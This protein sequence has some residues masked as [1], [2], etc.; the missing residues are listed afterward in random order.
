MVSVK[1]MAVKKMEKKGRVIK[2]TMADLTKAKK[3][4]IKRRSN[5]PLLDAAIN[6]QLERVEQQI[7]SRVNR[8]DQKL[9]PHLLQGAKEDLPEDVFNKPEGVA[10]TRQHFHQS[11]H[12]RSN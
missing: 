1:W 2:R 8:S 7:A 3:D 5:N 10:S 6:A 11:S 4:L 9:F 12:T